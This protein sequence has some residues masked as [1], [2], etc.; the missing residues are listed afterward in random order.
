MGNQQSISTVINDTINRSI[1]NVM[2]NSSQK[3]SQRNVLVQ[4]MNFDNIKSG[5]GCS[6]QFSNISQDAKQSVNFSCSMDSQNAS[7]LLSDFKTTLEQEAASKTG[8][9]G[10]S[11][12]SQAI[13]TVNNALINE[14]TSN[15]DMN[16]VSECIQETLDEQTTNFT[17]ITGY[18]PAWCNNPA[19][20]AGGLDPSV[21]VKLCDPS[22]CVVNFNNISQ[23]LV[24]DA[25]G[26]CLSSNKAVS[27]AVTKA[28]NEISQKSTS[29]A[30][31][32]DPASFMASML[33]SIISS[34]IILV[35][36][37][38][39]AGLYMYANKDTLKDTLKDTGETILKSGEMK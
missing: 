33:P 23:Q 4:T 17:N 29:A 22:Q 34:C 31:G 14:V 21:A 1:T 18:C 12:N 39:V 13:S 10:G 11:V 6:L 7:S 36:L 8:G 32:I 25:T 9:L 15:I 26:K 16:Q 35:I 38:S 20:C 30:T 24:Q 27:D 3:C 5:P 19:L 28:S 2:M 37:S